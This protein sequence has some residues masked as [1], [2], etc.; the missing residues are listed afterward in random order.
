[1]SENKF[2]WGDPIVISKDA[3]S[4]FHPGEFG[5]VCGFYEIL[6]EEGTKK[7]QC[8]LGDWVYTIEFE[9][10]SDIEIAECFL[11]KYKAG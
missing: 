11:E 10:G 5:S 3:P 4:V 9:D 2:T 8:N 7:F 6:S 1:M